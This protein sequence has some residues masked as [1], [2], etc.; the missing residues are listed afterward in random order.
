MFIIVGSVIFSHIAYRQ[1]SNR[2]SL[3]YKMVPSVV[4]FWLLAIGHRFIF[5]SAIS[6]SC[7]AK[8][9]TYEKYDT[10]FEVVVSGIFPP[11][12]LA[13]LGS[14]LLRSV[15]KVMLRRVAQAPGSHLSQIQQID[16][17]L[18]RML[19]LQSFVAIPSFLPYAAQNIY[20]S[21][22][23]DWYKSPLRIAWDNVIIETIRLLSY[24]FYSTSFYISF[25]SSRTFRA[26]FLHC[27]VGKRDK[28]LNGSMNTN[29]QAVSTHATR[30]TEHRNGY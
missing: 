18:T 15:R 6:G 9:G 17:Q 14:L 16:A 27:F 11:I 26:A 22:T 4:L 24:L 10:Y 2:V 5:Y 8:P 25:S 13:V 19:L 20:S 28:N 23:Q 3:A 1:W 30:K 21:I 12:I 7:V 29:A